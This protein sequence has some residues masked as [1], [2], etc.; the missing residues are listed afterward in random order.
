MDGTSQATP[1]VAG[2]VAL[3]LQKNPELTPAQICQI[4]EET[5][6]KLTPNKSNITGVGRVDA[7]AAVNAVPA[8]DKVNE[9]IATKA[10]VYPNPSTGFVT[11]HAQGLQRV[12]ILDI[13]GKKLITAQ[14]VHD[15]LHLDLRQLFAGIYFVTTITEQGYSTQKLIKN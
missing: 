5:S 4:L 1:C 15:E 12:E 7:L 6:V 8:W 13:T 3:M 11:V 10:L 9:S 14:A 2:I